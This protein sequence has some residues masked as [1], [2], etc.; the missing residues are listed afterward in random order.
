MDGDDDVGL[1]DT[2]RFVAYSK[3][4]IRADR[5]RFYSIRCIRT[6][7]YQSVRFLLIRFNLGFADGHGG[8][9]SLKR[10]AS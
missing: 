10:L 8:R 2:N 1:R 3:S 7:I 5:G 6:G 4:R 9:C